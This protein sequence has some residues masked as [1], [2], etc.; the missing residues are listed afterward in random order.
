ML[1][2]TKQDWFR[3]VSKTAQGGPILDIFLSPQVWRHIFWPPYM[4]NFTVIITHILHIS[5][6]AGPSVWA[7]STFQQCSHFLV[8][9]QPKKDTLL[10]QTNLSYYFL[11]NKIKIL[12]YQIWSSLS[13][14]V[15][16]IGNFWGK[17][18]LKCVSLIWYE[19][20]IRLEAT[21]FRIQEL[22]PWCRYNF[23]FFFSPSKRPSLK[24][25]T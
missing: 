15:C 13:R 12:P 2:T 3:P 1:R 4:F 14:E 17:N 19:G 9:Y 7:V 20:Q 23:N 10:P 5:N 8:Y 21:K 18:T 6:H 25:S 16:Y 22:T 24:P 11:S